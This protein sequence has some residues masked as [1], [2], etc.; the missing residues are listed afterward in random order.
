MRQYTTSG[1]ASKLRFGVVVSRFNHLVSA[2]IIW[3]R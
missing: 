3:S 1:D 2:S